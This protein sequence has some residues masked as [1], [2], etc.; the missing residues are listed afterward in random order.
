MTSADWYRQ[1]TSRIALVGVSMLAIALVVGCDHARIQAPSQKASAL[2]TTAAIGQESSDDGDKGKSAAALPKND[3]WPTRQVALRPSDKSSE[4]AVEEEKEDEQKPERANS[5]WPVKITSEVGTVALLFGKNVTVSVEATVT[6]KAVT[7]HTLL[8]VG[9]ELVMPMDL[10]SNLLAG[11]IEAL[12]S[13][14][15]K[16]DAEFSK[17]V[18]NLEIKNTGNENTRKISISQKAGFLSPEFQLDPDNADLLRKLLKRA[19][20][21]EQWMK[22]R[23]PVFQK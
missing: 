6:K 23:A 20:G 3:P 15:G 14:L 2:A 17:K 19:Q 22:E 5:S 18:G 12:A 11:L 13:T 8:R 9:G 10:E 4:E 21:V 1:T 16:P 7:C